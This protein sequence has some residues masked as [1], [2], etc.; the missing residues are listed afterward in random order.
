[1][2]IPHLY[3][4]RVLPGESFSGENQFYRLYLMLNEQSRTAQ[5]VSK[6]IMDDTS[7]LTV[8]SSR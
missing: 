3:N 1:M 8:T 7:I 5:K 4:E 6:I 2:T